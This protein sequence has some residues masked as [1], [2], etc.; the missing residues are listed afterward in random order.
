MTRT[1]PDGQPIRSLQLVD[2]LAEYAELVDAELSP[3][4]IAF[5]L[6]VSLRTLDRYRARLASGESTELTDAEFEY[7]RP[8]VALIRRGR[9]SAT[10]LLLAAVIEGAR[11][12]NPD[13]QPVA[14][15]PRNPQD[16]RPWLDEA[17]R[18]FQARSCRAVWPDESEQGG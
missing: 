8:S 14:H 12:V 10:Q 6:G 11:A 2:R 3:K 16:S 18:R 13:G 9:A 15:R 17:G 1:G 5:E 7:W 4:R